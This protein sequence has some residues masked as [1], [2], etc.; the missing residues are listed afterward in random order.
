[1]PLSASLSTF[2][3][4]FSL[5]YVVTVAVVVV[6]SANVVAVEVKVKAP[7]AFVTLTPDFSFN[8]RE[9]SSRGKREREWESGRVRCSQL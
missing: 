3:A 1:M 9:H 7:K 6:E 5:S 2:P 8:T 4:V